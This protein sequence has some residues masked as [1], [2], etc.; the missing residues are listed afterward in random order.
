MNWISVTDKLP[1]WIRANCSINVLA[2][3]GKKVHTVYCTLIEESQM[4]V[5]W[6]INTSIILKGVTHW[7]PLPKLP[8]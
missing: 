2:T 5:W 3:D 1:D 6:I 4:E 8:I 7:M